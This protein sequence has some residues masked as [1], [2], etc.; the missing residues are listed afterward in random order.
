MLGKVS[1]GSWWQLAV[2]NRCGL[3]FCAVVVSG[4]DNLASF[5]AKKKTKSASVT[6][7]KCWLLS[8][9]KKNEVARRV[10]VT[11]YPP[12]EQDPARRGCVTDF[13]NGQ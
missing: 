10:T 8:K 4:W 13:Q 12:N 1:G 11:R 2:E 7:F 6:L 9:S 5:W 3:R